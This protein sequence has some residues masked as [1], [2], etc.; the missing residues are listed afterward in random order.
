MASLDMLVH[1]TELVTAH[2][3]RSGEKYYFKIRI[4]SKVARDEFIHELKNRKR[5]VWMR[6][7]VVSRL[8]LGASTAGSSSYS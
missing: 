8:C 7:W 5:I 4:L 6:N 1:S 3:A 2:V